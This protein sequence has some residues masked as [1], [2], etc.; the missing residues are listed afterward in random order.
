MLNFDY[1]NVTR[2][3]FGRGQIAELGNLL[4]QKK[5]LLIAGGGSIQKNGVLSQVKAALANN[6]LLEFWGVEPN[7]EFDTLMRAVEIAK[8]ENVDFLLAVGGGSVA[9]GTKFIAAAAKTQS[10]PWDIL[11]KSAPVSS[12]IPMGVVLTL[13][14]TG[15]ESNPTA[16][17]SRRSTGQKLHFSTPHCQPVFAILDPETTYSLPPRQVSNGI[18][19]TFV[20]VM[21]Q[22]LTYPANGTLQDRLAEG[23]LQTLVE[24]GPL[25]LA[26]PNDYEVRATLMWT[27]TLALNGLVGQGVPQDWATHMIGHQLTA[28]CNID[29]ARTLACVLPAVMDYKRDKKRDKILQYGARVFGLTVGDKTARIAQTIEKTRQFFDSVGT[30]PKLTSYGFSAAQIPQIIAGLER[31]GLTRLGEHGDITPTDAAKILEL[32]L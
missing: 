21:E 30:S 32:A 5:V 18:V 14:A 31:D 17:I 1:Q 12:A 10:N 19:D 25:A 28:L 22:Y 2:I 27:S 7:P 4:S 23:L 6:Q 29:H 15:S 26:Q 11:E 8:K 13:P 16:V 24:Q 9:D 3:L 20:H